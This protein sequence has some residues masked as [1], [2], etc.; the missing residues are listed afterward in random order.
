[1]IGVKQGNKGKDAKLVQEW[2][3]LH[4][5][6][7]K[8]DEDFGPASA[9]AL[10]QFQAKAGLAVTGVVDVSTSAALELPLKL[11]AAPLPPDLRGVMGEPEDIIFI[12]QQHL[13]QHPREVGGQNRGPWVRYYMDGNEGD[14]WAWCAGFTTTIAKQA[15]VSMPKFYSCDL[16][17]QWAKKNGKLHATP[18][19]GC[20]FL[21]MKS[22]VDAVHVGIVT[23][24]EHEIVRTIEGNTNDEGSREGYEVCSRIRGTKALAFVHI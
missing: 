11:A 7:V 12:A 18:R 9:A 4:G 8:I 5:N 16:L 20:L 3:C 14:A 21:S 6:L 17:L 22:P 10:R 23:G 2:L 13:K 15:G 19:V 1:M 24:V